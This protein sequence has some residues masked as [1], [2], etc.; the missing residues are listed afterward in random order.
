MVQA[1][2]PNDGVYEVALGKMS[3]TLRVCVVSSPL[4]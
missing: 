3:V 4:S 2:R 1:F